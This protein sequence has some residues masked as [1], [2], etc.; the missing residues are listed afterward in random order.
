MT[1][2]Q[3]LAPFQRRESFS[4]LTVPGAVLLR[5]R[6]LVAANNRRTWSGFVICGQAFR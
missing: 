4:L 1:H 5:G 6:Q 3:G 2:L